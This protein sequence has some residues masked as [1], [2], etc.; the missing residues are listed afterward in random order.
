MGKEIREEIE[1]GEHINNLKALLFQDN[2][3][4]NGKQKLIE[5]YENKIQE[6]EEEN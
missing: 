6:L 3:T 1:A 5:Y 4:Q 2:L